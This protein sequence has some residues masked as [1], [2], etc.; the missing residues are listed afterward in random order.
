[1]PVPHVECSNIRI[2]KQYRVREY[3]DSGKQRNFKSEIEFNSTFE[4]LILA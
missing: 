2:F 3:Y 4:D 1:M